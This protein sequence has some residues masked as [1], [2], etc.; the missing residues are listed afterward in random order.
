MSSSNYSHSASDQSDHTHTGNHTDT[1]SNTDS[2]HTT[3]NALPS[4]RDLL[5][6]SL[7]GQRAVLNNLRDKVSQGFQFSDREQEVKTQIES[8]NS[9][10]AAER[11]EELERQIDQGEWDYPDSDRG[12]SPM[13][14]V[15]GFGEAGEDENENTDK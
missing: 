14:S 6:M 7:N 10:K 12:L 8:L 11:S 15:S 9:V 1:N 2:S 5:Y 3:S 4:D 13:S